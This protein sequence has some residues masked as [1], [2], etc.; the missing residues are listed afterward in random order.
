[1]L[2][3][4]L[5]EEAV[6]FYLSQVTDGRIV[7]ACINSPLNVTLSGDSTGISQV[8][9]LLDA[10]K[11]FAGSLPSKLHIIRTICS[12]WLMSTWKHCRI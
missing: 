5:G 11:G 9:V 7:V 8:Q 4:G 10:D 6:Q 2:A 1:M 12:S 3:V